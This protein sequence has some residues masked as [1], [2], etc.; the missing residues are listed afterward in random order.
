MKSSRILMDKR[1]I[2][3]IFAMWHGRLHENISPIQEVKM[4]YK[5]YFQNTKKKKK[6]GNWSAEKSNKDLQDVPIE[7]QKYWEYKEKI[8]EKDMSTSQVR[9]VGTSSR[10]GGG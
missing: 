8:G 1:I 10:G 9:K 7:S 2:Q 3:L 4:M 5:N 6:R